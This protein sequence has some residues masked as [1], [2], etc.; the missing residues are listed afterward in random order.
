MLISSDRG[1]S[2]IVSRADSV[3]F[4]DDLACLLAA[5]GGSGAAS[6]AAGEGSRAAA[7]YVRPVDSGAWAA[8]TA[9]YYARPHDARTPMGS[10]LVPFSSPEAARAAD[11]E[12][13]A[14][15]WHDL[16][17]TYAARR[18]GGRDATGARP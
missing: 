8:A 6:P 16:A 3:R 5:I 7:I 4:Y 2:Q 1:A 13:R 11:G 10:G 14:L 15:A 17:S 9:A 12:G 18:L